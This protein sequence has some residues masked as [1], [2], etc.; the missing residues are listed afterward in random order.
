M[1]V[2][3]AAGN[4]GTSSVVCID[5]LQVR[6]LY[7]ANPVGCWLVSALPFKAPSHESS[8]QFVFCRLTSDDLGHRG[9]HMQ[10][11][12]SDGPF[13]DDMR[14]GTVGHDSGR[15]IVDHS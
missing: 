7:F 15:D 10:V 3:N 6:G 14:G 13:A 2:S 4:I 11:R 8:T 12:I 5:S 9:A 1:G